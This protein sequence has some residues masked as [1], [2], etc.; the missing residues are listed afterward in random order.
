MRPHGAADPRDDL[1]RRIDLHDVPLIRRQVGASQ[2]FRPACVR[3]RPSSAHPVGQG[4]DEGPDQ[5]FSARAIREEGSAL[6]L[7]DDYFGSE[8]RDLVLAVTPPD[9]PAFHHAGR[10][11]IARRLGGLRATNKR[12]RPLPGLAL[13]VLV[14]ADRQKVEIGWDAFVAE[15]G[16]DRG[17]ALTNQHRSQQ[18]AAELGKMLVENPDCWGS[19][20]SPFLASRRHST[21]HPVSLF[22]ATP[23]VQQTTSQ[24]FDYPRVPECRPSAM[25]ASCSSA[26]FGLAGERIGTVWSMPVMTRSV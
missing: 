17:E 18:G 11:K 14:S 16:I 24:G 2:M 10:Y 9:G 12:R 8:K 6:D 20:P 26:M 22:D 1:R 21:A 15:G 13:P 25:S 23:R 3:F 4:D 7:V 5:V 19:L